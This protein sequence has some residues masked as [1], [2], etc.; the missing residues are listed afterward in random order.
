MNNYKYTKYKIKYI[1][2][3]NQHGGAAQAA[4]KSNRI[5]FLQLEDIPMLSQ[6]KTLKD[7]YDSLKK[8][9]TTSS[10][11]KKTCTLAIRR[12]DDLIDKLESTHTELDSLKNKMTSADS[13]DDKKYTEPLNYYNSLILNLTELYNEYKELPTDNAR[14]SH[15]SQRVEHPAP[16]APPKPPNHSRR[17]QQLSIPI[18]LPTSVINEHHIVVPAAASKHSE[19]KQNVDLNGFRERMEKLSTHDLMRQAKV[20]NQTIK[21]YELRRK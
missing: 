20:C 10:E 5:T 14:D 6:V 11:I 1:N 17:P 3:K 4:Q 18:G 21:E 7:E 19:L 16:S 12:V 13:L 2:Y 9:S 8:L 15:R